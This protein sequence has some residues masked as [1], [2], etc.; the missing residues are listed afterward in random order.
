M[1]MSTPAR[2]ALRAAS[3]PSSA[4]PWA[5]ISLIAAQSE[6]NTPL[7]PHSLRNKSRISL[8]LP[9]A[10]MPSTVLKAVIT[11]SAPSS[12]AA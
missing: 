1:S 2:I 7:K 11:S 5:I 8:R 10:G 9:D 3:R 6:I 12:S 4:T